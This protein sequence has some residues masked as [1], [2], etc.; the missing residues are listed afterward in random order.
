MVEESKEIQS[1]PQEEFNPHK[2]GVDLVSSMISEKQV[3]VAEGPEEFA[4]NGEC[5]QKLSVKVFGMVNEI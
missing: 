5:V 3:E 1:E 4:K 2:L